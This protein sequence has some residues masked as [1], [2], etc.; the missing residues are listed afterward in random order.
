MADVVDDL[1]VV[2]LLLLGRAFERWRRVVGKKEQEDEEEE[3][4]GEGDREE[5]GCSG[6]EKGSSSAAGQPRR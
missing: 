4:E 3:E 1:D 5:M 6:S 2:V